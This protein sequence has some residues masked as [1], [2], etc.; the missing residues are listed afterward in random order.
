MYVVKQ[1]SPETKDDV[2][3]TMTMT[4]KEAAHPWSIN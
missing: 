1:Q 4:P 2:K 3:V